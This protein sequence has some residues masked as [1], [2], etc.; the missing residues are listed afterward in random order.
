MLIIVQEIY[1]VSF[2]ATFILNLCELIFE[3]VMQKRFN[4]ECGEMFEAKKC[5]LVCDSKNE[6]PICGCSDQ[7]QCIDFES[8]C[9]LRKFNCENQYGKSL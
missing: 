5:D 4:G 1:S 8:E 3:L 7:Q 2:S 9:E 6:S